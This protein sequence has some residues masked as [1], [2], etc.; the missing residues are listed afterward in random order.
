L[1]KVLPQD[2]PD[3]V[4]LINAADMLTDGQFS[5][6]RQVSQTSALSEG[7]NSHAIDPH[8]EADQFFKQQMKILD[9]SFEL[10]T[11]DPYAADMFEEDEQVYEQQIQSIESKFEEPTFEPAEMEAPEIFEAQPETM[12]EQQPDEAFTAV[13]SLEQLVEQEGPFEIPVPEFME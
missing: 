7:E 5:A 1:E 6:E 9:K 12:F 4:N 3:I 11:G 13:D 8:E 2:H 10:G